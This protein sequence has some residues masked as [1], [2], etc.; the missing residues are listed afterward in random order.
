MHDTSM[1]GG[2]LFGKVYGK[3]GMKVLDVGGADVFGSLREPLQKEGLEYISIDIEQGKGVDIV[4]KPGDPFPF[5]D[6][7]FDLIVTTSCFEHDPCFWMTFREMGRVLKQ[8]GYIYMNAPSQGYY[9]GFPGD[10]W[11]FYSD[12][13]QALAYWSGRVVDGTCYPV[14]V[15][16]TFHIM[17]LKDIWIDFVC[18]WRRCDKKEDTI[19]VSD[20]IRNKHGPLQLA[21]HE[22]GATTVDRFRGAW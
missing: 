10:N 7:H 16:E 14:T 19:L 6:G 2:S 13:G 5:P 11:R 21:L 18:V 3:E 12:A 15:E 4:Y 9:H 22:A 17:P 8:D 1:L 20:E